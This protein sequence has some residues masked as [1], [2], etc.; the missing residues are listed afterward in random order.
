MTVVYK[1]LG[2]MVSHS[3]VFCLT[4][5]CKEHWVSILYSK[6]DCFTTWK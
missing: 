2:R 4:N 3:K 1:Q 6:L 5:R